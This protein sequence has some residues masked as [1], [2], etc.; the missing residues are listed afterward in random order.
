METLFCFLLYTV[1]CLRWVAVSCRIRTEAVQVG[2]VDIDTD[3]VTAKS[4]GTRCSELRRH[5]CVY[6]CL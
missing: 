5:F 4:V 3:L 2:F 1:L 6:V